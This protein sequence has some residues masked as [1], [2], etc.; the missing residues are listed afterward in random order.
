MTASTASRPVGAAEGLFVRAGRIPYQGEQTFWF[1]G[2]CLADFHAAADLI[3]ATRVRHPRVD[4]VLTAP[5]LETRQRLR[6]EFPKAI[7]LPPPLPMTL[8]AGLYLQNLLVR[9]VAMLGAVDTVDRI[10]LNASAS[11]AVPLVIVEIEDGDNAKRSCLTDLSNVTARIDHYFVA[12]DTSLQALLAT[13]VCET[14]ITVLDASGEKRTS[15]FV[16]TTSDLLMQDLKLLRS[17][18]RP[19][20]R[21]LEGQ[22]LRAMDRPAS[23]KLL[24]FKTERLD[25]LDDL[26][27]ALGHPETILCLGNGPSSEGADVAE[28]SHDAL[29]RVNHIWLK[30]DFLTHPQMVFT[31]SK[32]TLSALKNTIFGLHT[33]KSEARLLISRLLHPRTGRTRYVVVE[34]F[35]LF[36]NEPR[37]ENVRPTNGAVMLVIAVALKPK[38]L[39]VSGMDLFSHPAGS[40]PGDTKTANAYTP[41][42]EAESELALLLEALSHYHGELT[43]LSPALRE[44]WEAFQAGSQQDERHGTG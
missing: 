16:A 34:R 12:D 3:E 43:I 25:S 32:K 33:I 13:G 29:F 38:C 28:V 40:Y 15:D 1:V 17:K 18:I 27:Q 2:H 21:Q 19:I 23:R 39:V 14:Q 31:N 6:E 10:I 4:M 8:T 11:R 30:R 22:T 9:G 24:S 20:R 26:R 36:L 42:H 37:W 7:V 41:G 35:G 44:R 5:Q